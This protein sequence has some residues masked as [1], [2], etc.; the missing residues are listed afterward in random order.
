[1]DK[2]QV[3]LFPTSFNGTVKAPPSK[4]L[5]HRALICAGLSKG[6]SYIE[7]IVYS[8]DINA[9]MFALESL[10]VSFSKQKG[11]LKVKGVKRLKLADKVINCNESGST[12]RFLIPLFSLTNKEVRFTGETELMNR[13][14]TVYKDLFAAQGVPL[15]FKDNGIVVN[16]SLKPNEFI[17]K[18]D[19]SSQFFSGL[20]FALPLLNSDST[21]LIQ[22]SLESKSY[23]D[24]TISILETFGIEIQEIENGYFIKGNQTYKPNNY[25]VEGDYS[26]AAFHLVGGVIGGYVEITDMNQ[27]SVQGD[28]AIIDI[29]QTMKGKV[30][31]TENGYITETSKTKSSIV[32]IKDCP[33]LGPIVSLLAALSSGTTRIINAHRLRI[34]ES[35]RIKSTV[36]TLKLLGANITSENDEIVVRGRK[37][38][39]GG[40]TVDS[41]NDHRI[42]MMVAIA[43][44]RFEKE[45]VLTRATS[46]NKSYPHF[47][48][49]FKSLGGKFK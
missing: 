22:G 11:G 21:I 38:L 39:T 8:E 18:G 25:R 30:V 5:S 37:T 45:V 27:E 17:L 41:Y 6:E 26:Q 47:F 33:D 19:V 1:M 40:V 29:I 43:S 16:G 14:Q 24:L 46:V 34:K 7:N 36:E 35:D 12:I 9:T 2:S 44:S 13:P 20:M 23:V 49:D 4:S 15:E 31:F 3:T 32:D 48:E 10:G 42:A 28:L